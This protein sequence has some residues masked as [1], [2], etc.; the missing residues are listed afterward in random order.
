ML[1]G[2]AFDIRSTDRGLTFDFVGARHAVP[3]E[4]QRNPTRR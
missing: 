4:Q 3:V 2:L 1:R